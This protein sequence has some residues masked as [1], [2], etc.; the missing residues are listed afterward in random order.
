VTNKQFKLID[1]HF[2]IGSLDYRRILEGTI[3]ER[4]EI[5]GTVSR[6]LFRGEQEYKI[7]TSEMT[8]TDRVKCREVLF[9]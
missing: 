2:Q 6:S 9:R 8:D 4:G 3:D 5:K 7:S 1:N